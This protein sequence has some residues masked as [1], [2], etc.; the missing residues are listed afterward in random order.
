MIARKLQAF[1]VSLL[2]S[3]FVNS[4]LAE[5]GTFA[6]HKSKNY[7][8]RSAFMRNFVMTNSAAE[9]ASSAQNAILRGRRA[10]F[11]MGEMEHFKL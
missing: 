6:C 9:L 11:A 10:L 3:L 1:C 5:A 4:G 2:S 8:N 7:S